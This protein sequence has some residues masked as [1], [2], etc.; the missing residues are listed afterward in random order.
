MLS[1]GGCP[2]SL[3][4]GWGVRVRGV[5]GLAQGP[6]DPLVEETVPFPGLTAV[7]L[8][9]LTGWECAKLYKC[10]LISVPPLAKMTITTTIVEVCPAPDS[11]E[12]PSHC[13]RLRILALASDHLAQKPRLASYQPVWPG[14][15]TAI[16]A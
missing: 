1:P 11:P 2:A 12:A 16:S 10:Q 6:Q 4:G 14:A 13:G 15:G 9:L 8:A 5:W 3:M 7:P